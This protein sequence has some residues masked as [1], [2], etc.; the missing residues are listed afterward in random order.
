M[1]DTQATGVAYRDPAIVGGSVDNTPI[2]ATTRSSVAATTVNATGAVTAISGTAVPGA[3]GAAVL[4]CS[5]TAGLGIYI[6]NTTPTFSA[7]QGSLCINTSGSSTS[8][9]L[10]VNTNG[11]TGWTNFTSAT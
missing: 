7:A 10:F 4:L 9:R 8:T 11:S 3:A 6:S 2:G 5:T 1:P